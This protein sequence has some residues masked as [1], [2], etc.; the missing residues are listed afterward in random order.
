MT[1]YQTSIGTA[2]ATTITVLGQNLAT[3]L[4]GQ[5]SFGELAFW[6]AAL[7][8][9]S[10]GELRLFE[11]VLVALADHGFT[12]SVIA[13]RL[14]LTGAPESVQ[15]A[16][17]AGLLGGGSRYLGVTE[18]CGR[19]LADALAAHSG[20]LPASDAGWDEVATAAVQ[21]Q[22]MAGRLVPGLGHPVHKD[23]DPRTPVIFRIA[24]ESGVLGPHLRL[25]AAVGRVHPAIIGRALPLNGALGCAAR[26]SPI[27]DS[28]RTCCGG[29]RC[30][31]GRRD[32]W[33]T[34]LRRCA[35]RPGRPFTGRWTSRS[36]TSRPNSPDRHGSGGTCDRDAARFRPAAAGNLVTMATDQLTAGPTRLRRLGQAL[37]GRMPLLRDREFRSYWSGQTISMFGDQISGIAIP[38]IAVLALR[39]SA[40]D[41]GYLTALVWLPSLLFGLHAG[42]WVDRRG[43][44]RRTMIG[45]DLG[46][47]ALLMTLPACWALHVLTLAQ[48]LGVAFGTGVLSVAFNVSDA[49]LFVAVVPAERYLEGNSLVYASRA[50]SFVGGPSIGGLLVQVFSAPLAVVYDALSFLGSAFFLHRIR[51]AEPPADRRGKGSVTKPAPVS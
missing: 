51:P 22:R 1:E 41:M 29:S 40:A 49:A 13:A 16:L 48:L 26:R 46:R 32:C 4:M 36:G 30:W 44:R 25:F 6:L 10:P 47:F 17:A 35:T 18:D 34:S 8:R 39:A 3:G 7:R 9:P 19:F 14:T 21:A 15:G 50:L 33:G 28:R 11:S 24:E 38:L 12:P 2:E 5:V 45:A 27:S 43:Q 42:A 37:T 20:P 23:G 31:P